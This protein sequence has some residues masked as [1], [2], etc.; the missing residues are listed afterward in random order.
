MFYMCELPY[1]S[2]FWLNY[3]SYGIKNLVKASLK[4]VLKL[5]YPCYEVVIVD[6]RSSNGS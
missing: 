6:N 2:I 4:S 1:V 5:D 3:N